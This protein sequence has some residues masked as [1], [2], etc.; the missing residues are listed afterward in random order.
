MAKTVL[1]E[2]GERLHLFLGSFAAD[3]CD[4]E[5]A[6]KYVEDFAY[7]ERLSVAGKTLALA[8][9]DRTKAWSRG[10]SSA[11]SAATWLANATGSSVGEAIRATN[12]SRNLSGLDATEEALRDGLL[13]AQQVSEIT[14][15]AVEAPLDEKS[16]LELSQ[17]GTFEA[18]R[19]KA[20]QV[21]AA[22]SQDLERAEKQRSL[23][24]ARRWTDSDGMR[25]YGISLT[26]EQAASFE[27]T[28]DHFCNQVFKDAYA[29]G[30][31]ESHEAYATDALVLMAKA[32]RIN[33]AG[34]PVA[35]G[36]GDTQVGD[37]LDS[38]VRADNRSSVTAHALLLIDASA[39]H[40]G[41]TVSGETCEVAGV[42][43]I[44]VASAKNL[45]G[46]AIVDIIIKDGVDVRTVAHGGRT[47]NR[48]QKAALLVNWECEIKGCNV[49]RN[50][51]ID[52]IISYAMSGI[53]D[54]EHLG[55]KCRWHHGLKT[56]KG[57]RDGPRDKD[58]K[59]TLI[60]PDGTGPPDGHQTDETT[61]TG[62]Q[63]FR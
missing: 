45:F 59:R 27:P 41:Y 49:T 24:K 1:S 29:S 5:L 3:T 35:H 58:G 30:V 21:K 14:D 55:P 47:A 23:R 16:L 7:I 13:S 36:N 44:D 61:G 26:P 39:F 12:T 53:T 22:A 37:N 19:K 15:A 25:C 2:L 40:R 9:V 38:G 42:G 56:Y 11:S 31:K 48:R 57:W 63:L 34:D 4:G 10:G 28:W 46:D 60:P 8:Q 54:L 6:K 18:L 17:N 43:P 62:Q 51:D 50:L 52:H 32:A 20:R 33:G